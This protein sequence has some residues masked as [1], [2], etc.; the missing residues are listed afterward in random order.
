MLTK[1]TPFALNLTQFH[2]T[3]NQSGLVLGTLGNDDVIQTRRVQIRSRFDV[4]PP[5]DARRP[6][7]MGPETTALLAA[8]GKGQ[9]SVRQRHN[10]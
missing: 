10:E 8:A 7:D 2:S 5:P 6:M 9:S 4:N 3:L 1:E